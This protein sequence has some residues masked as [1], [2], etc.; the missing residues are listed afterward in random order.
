V[1]K[2]R[3]VLFLFFILFNLNSVEPAFAQVPVIIPKPAPIVL[4]LDATGNYKV[5]L[6]DLAT[7]TGAYDAITFSPAAFSCADVGP[8]TISVKASNT[9][10]NDPVARL[11]FPYGIV[12]DAAGN[13]YVADSENNQIKR[14][15]PGG[16]VTLLAGSG[17]VGSADGTGVSTSFDRPWGLAID[18]GGNIYVA[19]AGG[20]KIRKITPSGVVSTVAGNGNKGSDDGPAL[21]AT[22]NN[23]SGVAVDAAGN[24]YVV[25]SE[26]NKIRKVSTNGIVSTFAGSGVV[27][28]LDGNG[29]AAGFYN[30]H[31][32]AINNSTGYLY[33]ADGNNRIRMIS[34]NADVTTFAGFN[35]GNNDGIGTAASF[36]FPIGIAIDAPG[37]LYVADNSN[38][39]IRKVDVS[40][41]VTTIVGNGTPGSADGTGKNASMNAPIGIVL[42][43]DGNLY[44]TEGPDNKI[45][46]IT[47]DYVVTTLKL[48]GSSGTT[49]ESASKA[50]N[51][52]VVSQPVITSTY[53][54]LTITAYPGCNPSLRDYTLSAT[55]TDNC[56][57]GPVT[58]TQLPAPGAPLTVGTPLNVTLTATDVSGS[59]ATV[60]FPVN[61]VNSTT[62]PVSF[63]ANPTIFAVN[64]IKLQPVVGPDIIGY[65]WSPVD[66]LSD[67]TIA[68][69]V[70]NPATKTT[71]T[72]TVTSAG[73]CTGSASVTV[74]VLAQVTIPTAFTPNGDGI[75]DYWNIAHLSEYPSCTVDVFNRG[76]QLIFHS[77]G[78]GKPWAGI[79]NGASLP[80][81]TY[82]YIID[83]K[84][85]R[86]KLS[87]QVTII[88]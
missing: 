82:Y 55:A 22:F 63:T 71:Y 49:T 50:I 38:N 86:Q 79:Y 81:G 16:I 37:N 56:A 60:T 48:A 31:G 32:I 70:A 69:P 66:G 77:M 64:G 3:H 11:S 76:G 9:T 46:K 74:N 44:V 36:Y 24:L 72:L 2:P 78:Y 88:K 47:P 75:N 87:G 23:P 14:I 39:E 59:T 35:S 84:D 51:V 83:L 19:D 52:T 58:F 13:I 67:P 12:T 54:N 29:T 65:S 15:T 61:V 33:V 80:T 42:A 5:Q 62:E 6:S 10:S 85:G 25:D 20:S 7:I 8:Q 57:A 26:N 43:S 4:H 30:P 27:G 45:R 68:N 1:I 28:S 18:A 34:P 73:G 53:Q 17:V 40:G 21:S 41:F